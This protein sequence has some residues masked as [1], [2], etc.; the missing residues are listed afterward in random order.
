MAQAKKMLGDTNCIVGNLP[1]SIMS[2]RHAA[3]VKE[4]CRKL[5]ETCAPGG[6][7]ILSRR[8]QH[9]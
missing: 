4:G 1:I 8:R 5:I 2:Y 6:G 9:G 7:Y 3:E